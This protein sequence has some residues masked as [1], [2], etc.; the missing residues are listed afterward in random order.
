LAEDMKELHKRRSEGG[1]WDPR[2]LHQWS[3]SSRA[4]TSPE[5]T[6]ERLQS[7]HEKWRQYSSDHDAMRKLMQQIDELQLEACTQQKVMTIETRQCNEQVKQSKRR[8]AKLS[9][10]QEKRTRE[11]ERR[12]REIK[13]RLAREKRDE[14]ATAKKAAEEAAAQVREAVDNAKRARQRAKLVQQRAGGTMAQAQR[15]MEIVAVQMGIKRIG[16]RKRSEAE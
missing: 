1:G 2:K 13:E 12:H 11:L 6:G 5:T 10:T 3:G 4:T 7:Q 16:K 14:A 15:E 9:G 8:A